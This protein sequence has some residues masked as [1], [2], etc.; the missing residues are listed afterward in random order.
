M[1]APLVTEGSLIVAE[2]QAAGRG[3]HQ[4]KWEGQS[5]KNLTFSLIFQPNNAERL[6]ILTFACA[7]AVCEV[8]QKYAQDELV[9]LKWP[10]D[11]LV[12]DKKVAGILTETV[13]NGNNLERVVVG[14]GLN[15]NQMN[16]EG[17]LD[18][19]ATSIAHHTKEELIREKL[20]AE[21]LS[22]MEYNYQRW[23]QH[24]VEFIKKVNSKMVGYGDWVTLMVEGELLPGKYKFLGMNEFGALQ[25]LNK[26]YEVKV[27][28]YEQVRVNVG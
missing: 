26:D 1:P 20:L 19:K 25:V 11:V 22:R 4:K 5:G 2:V 16:F 8:V 7:F 17:E 27:F 15:V 9:Q 21:I 18:Q 13:F 12:N 14:I 6:T 24:D 3:Q 10:N 28:S 23:L